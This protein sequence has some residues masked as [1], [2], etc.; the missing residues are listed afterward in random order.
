MANMWMQMFVCALALS[1]TVAE[2]ENRRQRPMV[3]SYPSKDGYVKTVQK[4]EPSAI[5]YA[6]KIIAQ[7]IS[8][9]YA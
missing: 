8:R 1:N 5:N 4:K 6:S 3:P 9:T 7:F 2:P